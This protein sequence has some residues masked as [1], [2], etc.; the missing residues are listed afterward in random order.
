MTESPETKALRAL[1]TAIKKGQKPDITEAE[2]VLDR[3]SEEHID[4]QNWKLGRRIERRLD[5]VWRTLT[6]DREY[7]LA[8]LRHEQLLA[9]L[10]LERNAISTAIYA[11]YNAL[12]ASAKAGKLTKKQFDKAVKDFFK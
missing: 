10:R 2:A 8:K 9:A 12:F 7:T 4:Y 1:V 6:A 5:T 3:V 11:K